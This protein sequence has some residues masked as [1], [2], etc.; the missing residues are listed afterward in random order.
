MNLKSKIIPTI[1]VVTVMVTLISI[2]GYAW[3]TGSPVYAL[4]K[5]QLATQQKATSK[6]DAEFKFAWWR[7]WSFSDEVN[8]H[9]RFVMC[10]NRECYLVIA[11]K[12]GGTWKIDSLSPS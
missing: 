12:Q 2:G 8:G 5:Q 7:S 9:A 3:I 10:E 11:S 6:A 4:A 1:M